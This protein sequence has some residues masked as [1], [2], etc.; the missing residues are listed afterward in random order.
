MVLELIAGGAYIWLPFS[1]ICSLKSPQ[2]AHLI[3]LIWKPV[4]VTLNNGDTHS[5]WL[6]PR[7]SG[8]EKAADSLRLCRETVWQDGP[9]E[10]LVQ[11]LG[12]RVWLTGHG[13][14]SLLDLSTCTFNT[15]EGSD[16]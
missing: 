4:N 13:D 11:A 7:Y 6:F 10:T 9:G 8:S 2:P 12:Q 5:A 15:A 16:A 1:Q 3:D 14:I